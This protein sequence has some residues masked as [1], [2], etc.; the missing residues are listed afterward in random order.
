MHQ[1]GLPCWRNPSFFLV[2]EKQNPPSAV[3][4]CPGGC[5]SSEGEFCCSKDKQGDRAAGR[6]QRIPP[7][8]GTTHEIPCSCSH[9]DGASP[10][11]TIQCPGPRVW[12]VLLETAPPSLDGC[13]K[14]SAFH[15]K[16]G[17]SRKRQ[18]VLQFGSGLCGCG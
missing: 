10:D 17:K 16:C 14:P 3:P 15:P 6:G 12:A 18:R 5:C 4:D 9:R 8:M 1:E 2:R 7:G 11:C 13:G